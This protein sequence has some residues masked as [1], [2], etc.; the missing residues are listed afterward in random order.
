MNEQDFF[1][2]FLKLLENV[3][4]KYELD[5]NHDALILWFGE[6]YL[7]LDPGDVRD[8]IVTDACAEG[9]DA[10]LLDEQ[11]HKQIFI[12]AKTVEKFENTRNNF[13][14]NDI[15]ST[16][17]GVRFLLKGD[18]KGKITPELENLI[19]EYHELDKT[20]TYISEV[21]FLSLTGPPFATKFI[22]DFESEFK[23]VKVDL[24]GFSKLF[25]F[26]KDEYLTLTLGP[27]KKISFTVLTTLLKKES[28]HKSNI[29]TTKGEELARI[30][31][32]YKE[33]IFQKNVRYFL[34]MRAKSINSQV[35]ETAKGRDSGDFWYYNNGITIVCDQLVESTSGKVI[36]LKN[37]QII[38]G[39][40]TTY[41]LYEAYQK[42]EL[43]EDVEILVKVIESSKKD[44]IESVTLYTNSQNAI[45]LRDLLSNLGVQTKIQ[46]ILL[47]SYKHFYERKRGEFDSLYPTFAAKKEYFGEDYKERLISNENAAQAFLAFY[48]D[49]PAQAKS[50]KAKIFMKEGGF[51]DDI[52]REDDDLLPEKLYVAWKLLGYVAKRKKVYNK[53][54]KEAVK[55][56]DMKTPITSKQQEQIDRTYR[57]DFLL[58]GEYFILNL[59]K[60]FLINQEYDIHHKKNSL[61]SIIDLLD[62]INNDNDKKAD[63]TALYEIIVEHLAKFIEKERKDKPAY[64]HNKFFK[65]EKSIG[66]VR[67]FFNTSKFDF[68]QV[69][70]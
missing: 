12:Q 27:P 4:E 36:N 65:N 66:L 34:G 56:S 38:N 25:T 24:F 63:I 26:Y 30:Y 5:R 9:I 10:V 20:G 42:G 37:A 14:E 44:F 64:Y 31:N 61:L 46:K 39:A 68:V 53:E 29:F 57:F 33:S 54:Y 18:Y 6:N 7:M 32:D 3:R 17:A 62:G 43:K 41:A 28:P 19:D 16:L 59:F 47:D 2:R 40:Q 69:I 1:E 51:Y 22:D 15:K 58:H 8:R 48:L 70:T 52:F 35:V 23:N 60:D 50:N 55:L 67:G 49:K 13:R 45:R 11:N 21:I